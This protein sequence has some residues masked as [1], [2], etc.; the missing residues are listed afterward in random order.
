MNTNGKEGSQV[1]QAPIPSP[2]MPQPGEA[3]PVGLVPRNAILTIEKL[4]EV[5]KLLGCE[6]IFI[7][8]QANKEFN[9]CK[10]P[11]CT[12]QHIGAI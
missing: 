9:M 5:K 4:A 11:K 2:F 7:I 8:A 3:V 12:T 6:S 10:D 1:P